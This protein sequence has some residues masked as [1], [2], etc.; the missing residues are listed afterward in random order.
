LG[1]DADLAAA[2]KSIGAAPAVLEGFV[3][4][5]TAFSVIL[6]RGT[7]GAMAVWDTP[8]NRHET[9]ILDTSTVPAPGLVLDQAD[10]AITLA[11]H[12]AD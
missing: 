11:R 2:W 1:P 5:E 10:A 6:C 12:V 3:Q 4:F 7:D 9:G 8:E